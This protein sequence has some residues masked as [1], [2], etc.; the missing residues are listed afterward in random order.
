MGGLVDVGWVGD[1]VVVVVVGGWYPNFFC[2]DDRTNGES[3]AE[4]FQFVG[5][6]VVRGKSGVEPP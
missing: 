3:C 2:G 6:W 5:E 1:I 4:F